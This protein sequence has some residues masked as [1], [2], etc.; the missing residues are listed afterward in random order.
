MYL[1]VPL[2][3]ISKIMWVMVSDGCVMSSGIGQCG[4]NESKVVRKCSKIGSL[5]VF[6][7]LKC[8]ESDGGIGKCDG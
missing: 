1:D 2:S 5:D 7:L 4:S 3:G 8:F 6:Q